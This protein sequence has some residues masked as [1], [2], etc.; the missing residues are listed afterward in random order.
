MVA[1]GNNERR[2]LG[3]RFF[4]GP[5]EQAV[6]IGVRGGLVVV[7]AAPALVDLEHDAA[8]RDALINADLAITDSG[9]MVILWQILRREKVF[10][11][12]GLQY[13]KLLL[14]EPELRAPRATFWIMP[15]IA[16]R[17]RNLAWLHDN[18]FATG[19]EDC[20]VAPVYPSGVIEDKTLLNR[21]ATDRPKHII[22]CL[23]GGVQERL[24]IFLKRSLDFRPGIHCIGA[25]I[26]FLTGDQTHIPAWADHLFL[27]WLFRCVSD[28]RKFVPRY[29]KARKLLPMMFREGVSERTLGPLQRH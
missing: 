5:P 9:F 14:K 24:G 21:L 25:A 17:D 27:G 18:G 16:A 8:Y 23:G 4:V 13:L 10:R 19:E 26:G 15:S 1:A 6:Q 7:P 2:I 12:S 11:I 28:P 20:Y 29:W 22:V 3:I